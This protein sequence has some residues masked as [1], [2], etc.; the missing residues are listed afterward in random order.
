MTLLRQAARLSVRLGELHGPEPGSDERRRWLIGWGFAA[1]DGYQTAYRRGDRA[2]PAAVIG[3]GLSERVQMAGARVSA[4]GVMTVVG[5]EL[6]AE[7]LGIAR[8]TG[9]SSRRE[10]AACRRSPLCGRIEQDAS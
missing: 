6:P 10:T 1:S 2:R 5:P 9:S 7:R 4:T 8:D 3:P